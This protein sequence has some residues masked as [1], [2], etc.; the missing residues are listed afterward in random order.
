MQFLNEN[1]ADKYMAGHVLN[2]LMNKPEDIECCKGFC[3]ILADAFR[4]YVMYCVGFRVYRRS[5]VRTVIISF[6]DNDDMIYT[7]SGMF[8]KQA[9]RIQEIVDHGLK[10]TEQDERYLLPRVTEFFERSE[11]VQYELGPF[12]T[13]KSAA[14]LSTFTGCQTTRVPVAC[15]VWFREGVNDNMFA[16]FCAEKVKAND[17]GSNKTEREEDKQENAQMVVEACA[18]L[19]RVKCR[20]ISSEGSGSG[21]GVGVGPV[22]GSRSEDKIDKKKSLS[23]DPFVTDVSVS[24]RV[25]G[26]K[27]RKKGGASVLRPYSHRLIAV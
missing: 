23:L 15:M 24:A 11:K 5:S 17:N 25:R 18:S 27:S 10:L 20:V 26:G 3:D 6:D 7:V 8:Q 2:E 14:C 16:R 21:V 4:F 9:A 12:M 22:S 1:D 19:K 13:D